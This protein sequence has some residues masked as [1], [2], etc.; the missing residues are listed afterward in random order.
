MGFGV[1]AMVVLAA[2]LFPLSL[3]HLQVNL[4]RIRRLVRTLAGDQPKGPPPQPP[5]RRPCAAR[6]AEKASDQRCA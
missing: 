3:H 4:H 1:V 6:Q 2:P 5:V